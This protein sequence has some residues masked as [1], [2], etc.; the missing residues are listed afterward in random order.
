ML[1]KAATIGLAIALVVCSSS[2]SQAARSSEAA[3]VHAADDA[4]IKAYNAGQVENVVA[5][6]DENAVIYAPGVAPLHGRA[7]IHE[8]FA[9]DMAEFA[10]TG[11]SFAL[12]ANPDGGVSGGLGW[13]S[14][15]WTLTDKAGKVADSGWYFSVSRKVG[16][17]WLYVR[18]SWNS[19][20]PAAPAPSA[21]K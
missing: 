9:K 13:S 12:D 4:W 19:E 5:L 14:G 20:K 6:Y 1:R 7:A 18:D 15:T 3:A 8:F 10:K 2:A 21:E 11:L 17:K 16:G